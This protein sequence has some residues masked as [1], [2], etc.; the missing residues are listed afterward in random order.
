MNCFDDIHDQRTRIEVARLQARRF[1]A[2]RTNDPI[3]IVFFAN[4]ALTRCPLTLDKKMLDSLCQNVQIG[5]IDPEGT[6]LSLGLLMAVRRLMESKAPEKV[7]I[8]LTDGSPTANDISP[9]PVIDLL[10][11]N[12]IRVYTIGIG[13]KNG[14]FIMHPLWG[15]QMVPPQIDTALLERYASQTGGR[16]FRAELPAELASIYDTIN[17]LERSSFEAPIYERWKDIGS[18]LIIP[19]FVLFCFELAMSLYWRII[20]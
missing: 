5:E 14:G 15:L 7:I 4:D 2:R 20:R 3:G 8:L 19:L 18:W 10:K 11:K 6:K 12:N 16:Y 9:D 13:N 17:R 1:I